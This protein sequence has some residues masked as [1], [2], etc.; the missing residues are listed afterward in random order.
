MNLSITEIQRAVSGNALDQ[1]TSPYLSFVLLLHPVCYTLNCYF[2]VGQE[3]LQLMFTMQ[4]YYR[5]EIKIIYLSIY[6]PIS[7]RDKP[8][9]FCSCQYWRRYDGA[10][11]KEKIKSFVLRDRLFAGMVNKKTC[12]YQLF[13]LNIL[14][15]VKHITYDTYFNKPQQER[16]KKNLPMPTCH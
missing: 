16:N 12:F 8:L 6:I 5:L 4:N 15:M 2:V 9:H 11:V 7:Y 1:L 13:Q 10:G 14:I 3:P